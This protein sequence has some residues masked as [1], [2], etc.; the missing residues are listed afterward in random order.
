MSLF[1][2]RQKQ[3]SALACVFIFATSACHNIFKPRT[4]THQNSCVSNNP[5]ATTTVHYWCYSP[6]KTLAQHLIY[7]QSFTATPFTHSYHSQHNFRRDQFCPP[8]HLSTIST[9]TTYQLLHYING[10][11]NQLFMQYIYS[12]LSSHIYI[13]N[14]IYL[15]I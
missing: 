12:Y 4:C 11:S 7:R 9:K 2:V 3:S 6:L 14:R 13:P 5:L 1:T 15:L 8:K 10:E